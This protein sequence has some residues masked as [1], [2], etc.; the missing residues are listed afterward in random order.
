LT[1]EAIL[2]SALLKDTTSELTGLSS[3]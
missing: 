3:H 1:V 2:L